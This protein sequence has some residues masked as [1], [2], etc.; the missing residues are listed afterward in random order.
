MEDFRLQ[1][2]D[3]LQSKTEVVYYSNHTAIATRLKPPSF[4]PSVGGLATTRQLFPA[5]SLCGHSTL[6][7][8]WLWSRSRDMQILTEDTARAHTE[9][10]A[11]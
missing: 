9:L 1:H 5:A 2:G 6:G 4:Q 8:V 3:N 7:A 10:N 11:M